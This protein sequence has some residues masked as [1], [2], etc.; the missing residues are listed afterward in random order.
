MDIRQPRPLSAKELLSSVDNEDH[1]PGGTSGYQTLPSPVLTKACLAEM[2]HC[3]VRQ[4]EKL[5]AS[6]DLPKPFQIGNS[7]RWL[8]DWITNELSQIG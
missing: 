8:R 3:S 4:I 5:V 1:A 6:G 2:L 7:P